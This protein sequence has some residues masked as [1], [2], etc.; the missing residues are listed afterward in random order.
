MGYSTIR[1]PEDWMLAVEH[2]DRDVLT[3][4]MKE[5]RTALANGMATTPKKGM[6]AADREKKRAGEEPPA[7]NC[8]GIAGLDRCLRGVFNR[9]RASAPR[10]RGRGK[11]GPRGGKCGE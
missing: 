2:P 8:V 1:T 5:M 9:L 6:R 11:D 10:V 3:T 4:Q 7:S